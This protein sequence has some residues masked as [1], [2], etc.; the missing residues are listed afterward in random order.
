MD[1]P[2]GP[3]PTAGPI[4]SWA[5]W[6][7]NAKLRARGLRTTHDEHEGPAVHVAASR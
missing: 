1:T 7:A 3:T 5:V 6:A 4:R 2:D